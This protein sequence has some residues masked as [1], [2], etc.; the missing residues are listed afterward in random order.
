MSL[1]FGKGYLK[2]K[3]I[4]SLLGVFDGICLFGVALD[5]R[6]EDDEII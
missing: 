2:K 1:V 5:E 4:F 3:G 6:G